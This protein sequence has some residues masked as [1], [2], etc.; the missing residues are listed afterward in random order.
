MHRLNQ[1]GHRQTSRAQ[2]APDKAMHA[3]APGPYTPHIGMR[4]RPEVTDCRNHP[5]DPDQGMGQ[6]PNGAPIAGE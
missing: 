5:D 2:P 6:G 1:P 3:D 4:Q